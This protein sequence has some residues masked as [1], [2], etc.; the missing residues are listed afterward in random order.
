MADNQALRLLG[1]RRYRLAAL[2]LALNCRA[3]L[4]GDDAVAI[5]LQNLF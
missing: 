5:A 2:A 1:L 4:P 3:L